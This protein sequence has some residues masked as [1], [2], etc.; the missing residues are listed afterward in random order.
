MPRALIT[1]ITGQDGSY[2]AEHLLA[3][4]YEVVGVV[5]RTSHHSYERIEHLIPRVQIVAADLLDQHSLTMVMQDVQP[6]EV[7][8]LAAQS[9]VPTSFTQP[10][11]TGEFTALGVTRILEA[12]RLVCPTR[13]LLPGEF[14]GN[15]RQGAGDAAVM[16]PR[17]SIRARRMASPSSTVTGSR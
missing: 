7:Y 13:A 5:R 12:V 8:N 17:R 3:K 11:L 10:V 2:L 14:V 6:D 9:F 16:R 4:G 1:G 15:V